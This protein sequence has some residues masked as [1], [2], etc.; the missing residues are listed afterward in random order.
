MVEALSEGGVTRMYADIYSDVEGCFGHIQNNKYHPYGRGF[1]LEYISVNI[2][3]E[4]FTDTLSTT[5]CGR[6]ILIDF[7]REHLSKKYIGE[8]QSKGFD[9]NE[10]NF[11]TFLKALQNEEEEYEKNK[12]ARRNHG[13][14]G[15]QDMK[16]DK[17]N[18]E[19]LYKSYDRA[20]NYASE[21]RGALNIKP[22]GSYK[23]Q[24]NMIEN[25]VL[26]HIPLEAVLCIGGSA[27]VNGFIGKAVSVSNIIVHLYG[28]STQGKTTAAQLAVSIAGSCDIQSS[29]LFMSWNATDNSLITRMKGNHGMPV[30]YDEISKY[31]G[32]NLSA[33]IYALSDSREKDRNNKD[34][35][36]K[37]VN[38]FDSWRTCIIST[39]EASLIAKCQNNTGLKVRV[40]EFCDVFTKSAANADAIKKSVQTDYGHIAPRIAEVLQKRIGYDKAIE[41]HQKY[42][43]DFI[44][45]CTDVPQIERLAGTV[46]MFAVS[47]YVMKNHLGIDIN[48]EGVIDYF[49]D[50]IKQNGINRDIADTAIEKIQEYVHLHKNRFFYLTGTNAHEASGECWGK[51]IDCEHIKGNNDKRIAEQFTIYYNRFCDILHELNYEDADVVIRALKKKGYLDCEEGKTYR[52]RKVS[53]SDASPSKVIVINIFAESEE[54]T[55]D[56]TTGITSSYEAEKLPDFLFDEEEKES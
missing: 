29:G 13:H 22:S 32:K 20:G 24:I 45:R 35:N 16:D 51:V 5:Y 18:T 43:E 1:G 2:E 44:N 40:L 47:A 54:E 19:R 10:F 55:D 48:I 21:Y 56:E 3:D 49:L 27:I 7:P 14:V 38:E 30:A 41:L 36:Q 31:Q 17:G 37:C 25:E 11:P 52:K 46:A 4:T 39:G 15:W 42:K 26:G 8:L 53:N 34:G 28:D 12:E 6:P 9:V 23:N 33:T 50:N